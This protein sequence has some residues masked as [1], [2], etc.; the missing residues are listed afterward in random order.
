MVF[1]QWFAGIYGVAK[2]AAGS[3]HVVIDIPVGKT[4]KVRSHEEALKLQY[5]FQA[6]AEAMGLHT[7]IIIT[8]GEQ[9]VGRGIGPALEAM[10]VLAVLRNEVKAPQYLQQRF[11]TL[12]GT[13]LELSGKY[14]K[15]TGSHEALQILESGRA[16]EKLI[17]ICEAQGGF[18]EPLLARYRYDVIARDDGV[19]KGVDN[20]KLARVAKLA[21]APKSPS[22]PAPQAFHV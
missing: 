2:A 9:P 8:D 15:G 13:L 3:P 1:S 5:Y 11:V 22:T 14:E 18:K 4:A 17:K 21:G 12:A 19:I 16:L 20:R 6:V 10:D 7:E